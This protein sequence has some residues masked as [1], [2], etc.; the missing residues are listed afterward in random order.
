MRDRSE[1]RVEVGE[2]LLHAPLARSP[3]GLRG[4]SVRLGPLTMML[5]RRAPRTPLHD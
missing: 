2:I 4:A 1:A 3:R 5:R